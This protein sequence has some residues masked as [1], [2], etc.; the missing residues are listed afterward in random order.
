MGAFH[1][2]S[3]ER[4]NVFRVGERFLFK[5]YFSDEVFA[6]LRAH[7]DAE[8][9][10]FE[11]PIER[12]EQVHDALEDNGYAPV[13]V[14]DPEAFAVVKRKYTDHPDVLFTESVLQRTVDGH[15]CFVMKDREAVDAAVTNGATRLSETDLSLSL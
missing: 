14:D 5:H 6:L 12:Y 7:Y 10:R 8:E 11:V 9:Y 15:N 2:A 4:V 1:P 13:V 3:A